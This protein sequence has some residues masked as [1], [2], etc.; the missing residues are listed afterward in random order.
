MCDST[1]HIMGDGEDRVFTLDCEGGG[2]AACTARRT[3]R[4]LTRGIN[5]LSFKS[6]YEI[7]CWGAAG[8]H[9]VNTWSSKGGS[10]QHARRQQHCLFSSPDVSASSRSM[11]GN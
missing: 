6:G 9:C 1:L 4:S 2:M 3:W 8:T 5:E 10:F 7:I 11:T